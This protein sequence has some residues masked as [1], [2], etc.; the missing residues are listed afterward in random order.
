MGT[1]TE[2]NAGPPCT[3]GTLLHIKLIGS[4]NAVVADLANGSPVTTVLITADPASGQAC[5]VSVQVGPAMPDPGATLL[6]T[7]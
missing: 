4:F 7:K 6:F 1:Q 5:L 2:A 3:S